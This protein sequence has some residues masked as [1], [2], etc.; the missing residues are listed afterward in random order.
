MTTSRR[1]NDFVLCAG[2][3]L[4]GGRSRRMGRDKA[5]LP[6]GGA[7]LAERTAAILSRRCSP[8]VEVGP[9]HSGLRS[10]TEDRP[11]EGPLAA[12]VAGWVALQDEGWRGPVVVVATDLPM[13]TDRF[14]TWIA[15]R[16]GDRSVVPV[17]S[18][19]VQ[20]LCARYSPADL[21]LARSLVLGGHRSMRALIDAADAERV[22]EQEWG[23]AAGGADVLA[24]VDTPADL[25]RVTGT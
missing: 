7:T 21:D 1:H 8:A 4:T 15:G 12:V 22:G 5:S 18:G 9:G 19:R 11:G 16:P 24:D 13:L 2:I 6:V 3:L 14:V 17:A 25:R 20:P 23:E 10:V